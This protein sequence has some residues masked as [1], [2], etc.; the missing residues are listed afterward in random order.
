MH[1]L[2]FIQNVLD[3]R[4]AIYQDDD[5]LFIFT[6]ISNCYY[7]IASLRVLKG[8]KIVSGT[9][10]TFLTSEY[11][12]ADNALNAAQQWCLDRLQWQTT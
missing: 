5:R 9:D 12:T 4:H 1:K 10:K 3:T 7:H 6:I 11:I 8:D 2:E